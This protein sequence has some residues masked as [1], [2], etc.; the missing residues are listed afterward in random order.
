MECLGKVRKVGAALFHGATRVISSGLAH[1]E[2]NIATAA[3]ALS[4]SAAGSD[5]KRIRAD[6]YSEGFEAGYSEASAIATDCLLARKPQLIA[7]YLRSGKDRTTV[8]AELVALGANEDSSG[9]DS[10]S[11]GEAL[12]RWVM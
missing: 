2:G 9:I 12:P 1:R 10:L 6:A 5:V 11:A 8:L 4:E 7:S 3:A